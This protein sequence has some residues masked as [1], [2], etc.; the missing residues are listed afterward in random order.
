MQEFPVTV[1]EEKLY[2]ASHSI[3]EAHSSPAVTGAESSR[4][5]LADPLPRTRKTQLSG[6]VCELNTEPK[7]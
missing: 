4:D 1:V 3:S 7:I 6:A 5:M 2:A